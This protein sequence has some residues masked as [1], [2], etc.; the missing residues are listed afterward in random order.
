MAGSPW[1]RRVS[2]VF[3]VLLVVAGLMLGGAVYAVL[4]AFLAR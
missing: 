2:P 4:A 1:H 3:F